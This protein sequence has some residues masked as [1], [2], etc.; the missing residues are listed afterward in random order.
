M[1]TLVLSLAL[2]IQPVELEPIHVEQVLD[3][4][5]LEHLDS[6]D[7]DALFAE[8]TVLLDDLESDGL[9]LDTEPVLSD[10]VECGLPTGP[11]LDERSWDDL[12]EEAR[13]R[14][15]PC[16]DTWTDHN[17]ED[18]GA[19]LLELMSWLAN[20]LHYGWWA[21]K[22]LELVPPPEKRTLPLVQP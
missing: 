5:T 20:E 2:T 21:P 7:N 1:E 22:K 15:P 9:S 10:L 18:P 3:I 14:I 6:L 13:R 4:E 8:L 19:A 11:E 16:V 17:T 12:V